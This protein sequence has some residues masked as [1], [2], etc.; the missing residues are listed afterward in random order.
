VA[1]ER[2]PSFFPKSRTQT[3]AG[4]NVTAGVYDV[5]QTADAGAAVTL[6]GAAGVGAA[7]TLFQLFPNGSATLG[8]ASG[9]AS[10]ALANNKGWQIPP[11]T[12]M[13]STAA[14]QRVLPVGA[15]VTITLKVA[16]TGAVGS[17]TITLTLYRRAAGVGGALTSLGSATATAANGA[18]GTTT[19]AAGTVTIAGAD[20]V[21]AP[22]ETFYV[23][24][25]VSVL[26]QL[27]AGTAVCTLDATTTWSF[28]TPNGILY[29]YLQSAAAGVSVRAAKQVAVGVSR[30]A[31]ATAN[32][33]KAVKLATQ[34]AATM[35]AQAVATKGLKLGPKQAGVVVTAAKSLN[36]GLKPQAAGVT[37]T[38]AKRVTI[39]AFRAATITAGAAYAKA[40]TKT[41]AATVTASAS[42]A[43]FLNL[44]RKGAASVSTSAS[45]VIGLPQTVLNRFA[46]GA[47]TVVKKAITYIFGD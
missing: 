39:G 1:L 22:G 34:K 45:A 26:G 37:L 23:E 17:D 16:A 7:A 19:T 42:L 18:T 30:A 33:V 20:V 3:S 2:G 35:N 31:T 14:A 5:E 29:R 24:A 12:I 8:S 25:Y 15:A 11:L 47:T 46:G 44:S 27:V 28:N 40:I 13:G 10:T 21:L 4:E 36:V 9:V 43:K 6:T 32:A 41:I 38:A